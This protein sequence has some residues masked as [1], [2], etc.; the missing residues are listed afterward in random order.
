MAI[1]ACIV[2]IMGQ[3]GSITYL[4]G[5]SNMSIYAR[6]AT[7]LVFL[8]L[9]S[10]TVFAGPPQGQP[11]SGDSVCGELALP[12]VSPQ[13]LGICR[14]YCD[15]LDCDSYAAGE[16]PSNCNNLLTTYNDKKSDSDPDLPCA[17]S[18]V[19]CPCWSMEDLTNGG[20][21]LTPTICFVDVEPIENFDAAVYSGSGHQIQFYADA[22]SGATGGCIYGNTMISDTAVGQQTTAEENQ[23][24]RDQIHG[25]QNLDF[26]SDGDGVGNCIP[27]E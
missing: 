15:A 9:A 20:M 27:L 1:M 4:K 12:G 16:E 22:F 13:L 19:A 8:V 5:S 23:A 3:K 24:C 14:A 7:L 26:D 21:G 10:P 6:I 25:L 11:F 18:G 17:Q 2:H